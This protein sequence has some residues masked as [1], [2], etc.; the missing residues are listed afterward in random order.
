MPPS[1]E[2][3]ILSLARTVEFNVCQRFKS[4]PINIDRD[5]M[6]SEAWIGAIKA[7]DR[8][9]PSRGIRLVTFADHII[10]GHILDYLRS[11]DPCSRNMRD[12][13][14]DSAWAPRMVQIESIHVR[15]LSSEKAISQVEAAKDVDSLLDRTSL[16]PRYRLVLKWRYWKDASLSKI[17]EKLQVHES[18]ISQIHKEA[19]KKLRVSILSH[20]L[21][22]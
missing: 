15:D 10:Q 13:V 21:P 22:N 9:D 7:V 12:Q 18:R 1:R 14:K 5:D 2:E 6:F 4:I 11:L 8:F 16:T 20:E 17:G 19:I 3:L